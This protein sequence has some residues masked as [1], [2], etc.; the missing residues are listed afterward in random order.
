MRFTLAALAVPLALAGCASGF[1]GF[2]GGH[3]AA[4]S[5]GTAAGPTSAEIEAHQQR[6]QSLRQRMAAA[7]T[8]QEREAL[9]AEHQQ[10][11]QEGA[12][13]GGPRGR[14]MGM[15]MGPG[16]GPGA[17]SSGT[18]TGS[19]TGRGSSAE[20][21]PNQRSDEG[22]DRFTIEREVERSPGP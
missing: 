13:M 5:R 20:A 3:H 2:G 16:M 6:M 8:E 15:G 9:R 22:L 11:M 4:S 21:N 14:G 12:A 17:S 18:T 19:A 10:L 1:P 7:Q